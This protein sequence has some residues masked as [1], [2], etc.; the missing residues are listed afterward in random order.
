MG[1]SGDFI[2]ALDA[3]SIT[4]IYILEVVRVDYGVGAPV[5]IYSDRGALQIGRGGVDIRGT[6]V[7]PQR[8][9]VSFGGFDLDVVGDIRP[10]RNSLIRGALCTL[11]VSIAGLADERIAIG[12]LD[13]ITGVRGVYRLRFKDYLSASQSRFDDRFAGGQGYSQ[14]FYDT[15]QATT[16]VSGWTVG[17]TSLD[18]DRSD[19]FTKSSGHNGML[20]CVP[21]S[22][23][24][25]Y[26]SWSSK[27]DTTDVFTVSGQAS[28]PST[29]SASN[30][31]VGDAV[32]NAA[33]ILAAPHALFA[34]LVTSTG[35]GT[36]GVDDLLPASYGN[37][38]PLHHSFFDRDDANKT[39]E[40]ILPSTGTFYQWDVVVNEPLSGGMRSIMD[41]AAR[42]GQWPVMR[43][44]SFSWRG[45]SD[46]TG[47]FGL[48]PD[49]SAHIVD[50]D[51]IEIAGVEFFD[52]SLK[53]VYLQTSLF[54]NTENT[55]KVTI[56]STDGGYLPVALEASRSFGSYYSQGGGN[57]QRMAS[58]DLSRMR[59]WDMFHWTRISLRVKLRFSVLCAG[60]VVQLTSAY[61]AD[62]ST[63][64]GDTYSG[65][66]GMVLEVG[67]NITNRS[68]TVVI[69][70]PPEV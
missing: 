35:D 15:T 40:Y 1:W 43:Q 69:G 45:C 54:Y 52:P 61:I 51:I 5:F 3:P 13:Q 49:T 53:A 20:Y 27:N 66:F 30:L 67:Y 7:T 11:R 24:P 68:C 70:F 55:T 10:Y 60:D 48:K 22:G 4:P 32:F 56:T 8:W 21:T 16:V 19:A 28:H 39:Q 64:V 23:S 14:F 42:V 58:G 65:R 31:Q 9:A 2:A 34:Q 29:V 63:Q 44:N 18:V 38:A 50:D 26:M 25:F 59:I 36:N 62:L 46:P 47:N 41:I 37:G 6:S 33:R 17:D 57:M 12:Q